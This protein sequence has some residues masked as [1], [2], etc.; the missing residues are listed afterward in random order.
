[1]S[2]TVRPLVASRCPRSIGQ[3]ELCPRESAH[4]LEHILREREGGAEER[5]RDRAQLLFD[6]ALRLGGG[7]IGVQQ[8]EAE[9]RGQDHP[10][11]RDQDLIADGPAHAKS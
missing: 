11:E 3:D 5:A 8:A 7:P 10:G 4:L 1:M 9:D 6:L 2:G